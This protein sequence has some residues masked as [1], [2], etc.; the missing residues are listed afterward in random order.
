MRRH[1]EKSGQVWNFQQAKT[2]KAET[3]KAETGKDGTGRKSA[4]DYEEEDEDQI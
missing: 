1:V 3:G 2:G 4:F